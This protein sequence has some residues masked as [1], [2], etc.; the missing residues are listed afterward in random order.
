MEY[1]ADIPS[2]SDSGIPTYCVYRDARPGEPFDPTAPLHF[3]PPKDSD[4]LFDALRFAFPH[5]NTHSERL[6]DATIKFLLEEQQGYSSPLPFPTPQVSAQPQLQPLTGSPTSAG[7]TSSSKLNVWNYATVGTKGK[8]KHTPSSQSNSQRSS[9]LTKDM[10][11]A[12]QMTGVFSIS[13]VQPKQHQRRKMTEKEK[14]EYR[15]RRTVKACDKCA[16]RKRKV[17]N[18]S[19]MQGPSQ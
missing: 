17:C 5:L 14:A 9:L 16:K 8:F 6:R 11:P 12:E 18:P 13:S 3:L 10:P 4:E 7:S 15:K 1:A 19:L 2:H